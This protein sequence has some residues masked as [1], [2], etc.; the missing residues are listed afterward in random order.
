MFL[1]FFVFFLFAEPSFDVTDGG[2]VPIYSDKMS[3]PSNFDPTR[4]AGIP[5][6]RPNCYF[7]A[8][9][10]NN[11]LEVSADTLS[12]HVMQLKMLAHHH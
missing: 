9:T 1:M 2:G 10:V 4:V 3:L 5:S 8:L 7:T 12:E 11:L 6:D